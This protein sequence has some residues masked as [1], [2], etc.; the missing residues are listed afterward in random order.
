MSK[1]TINLE[2]TNI[3]VFLTFNNMKADDKPQNFI[4][5]NC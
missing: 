3:F 4:K 2:A 5:T 1:F